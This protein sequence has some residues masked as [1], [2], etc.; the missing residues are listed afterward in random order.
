VQGYQF[1]R[2]WT[3][4]HLEESIMQKEE[5][6]ELRWLFAVI[7]RWVWLIVG[8]TLLALIIAFAITSRIRPTY[9]ATT[10]LLVMLSQDAQTNAYNSLQAGERLALTYGQMLKDRLILQA[11][12]GRLGLSES[13]DA[14]AKRIKVQ[15]VKD[16]QL[17]R[18]SVTDG[19][20]T[21]APVIADAI[22][23]EFTARVKALQEARYKDVTETMQA[24]LNEAEVLVS[25]AQSKADAAAAQ[26]IVD[27]AELTRLATFLDEYRSQYKSVEDDYQTLQ[28]TVSQLTDRVLVLDAARVPE[29]RVRAPYTATVTLLVNQPRSSGGDAYSTVMASERLAVTYAQ[30]LQEPTVLSAAIAQAGITESP[31]ALAKRVRVELVPDTQLIR[32]NVADIKASQATRLANVIAE[33]FVGQIRETMANPY[34]SRLTTMQDSLDKLSAAI[35]ETQTK[36]GALTD[37]KLRKDTEAARAESLL[38]EYRSNYRTL[39]Q[40]FEQL[41]LSATRA[42]DTVVISERAHAPEEP[43]S[44][45]WLYILLAVAMAAVGALG[46]AFLIEH[47]DDTVKTPEDIGRELGIATIGTICRFPKG[48]EGL[49]GLTHPNL[50]PAED[51]RVLAANLRFA[52]VDAPLRTLVVTSAVSG[53]GKSEVVANLAVAMAGIGV[54][55]IA[56]DADLRR[57]RLHHL[58]GLPQGRGLTESLR[59]GRFED[60]LR[61]TQ[62]DGLQVLTSGVLPVDPVQLISSPRMEQLLVELTHRADVVIVD[63]PPILGVA[64]AAIMAAV[65]DGVLLVLRA[66]QTSRQAVQLTIEAL[67]KAKSRL[68]GAVLNGIPATSNSY[69][70]YS[71]QDRPARFADQLRLKWTPWESLRRPS[72]VRREQPR[73]QE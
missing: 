13:P 33:T 61:D 4:T 39:Q 36:I 53:E 30:L 31:D 24:K 21:R 37:E 26:K 65:S 43:V 34:A 32:L 1:T 22:A 38:A 64:D 7:R 62:V 19:S 20:P 40:N 63:T 27:E 25:D 18:L 9:E 42:A 71:Q 12:I 69:Y 3:A 44:G 10:T 48:D 67:R 58:F 41:R 60:N 23:E 46:A 29:E 57:P 14:L 28:T 45:R 72:S 51:F 6:L 52:A 8:C 17:F 70:R 73:A 54:R 11:V 16:T 5:T 68:V 15:P 56:V 50:P 49:V 59:L 35:N 47:F 2:I 55:V 66:N